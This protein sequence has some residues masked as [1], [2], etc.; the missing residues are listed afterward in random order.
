M[1]RLIIDHQQKRLD[2]QDLEDKNEVIVLYITGIEV[3]D[4]KHI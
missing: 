1:F 2:Y 4:I 3:L